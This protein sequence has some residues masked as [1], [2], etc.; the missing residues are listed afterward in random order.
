MKWIVSVV[1]VVAVM[2]LVGCGTV[3]GTLQGASQ[4][5]DKAGTWIKQKGK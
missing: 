2:T 1:S 3:G 5:L 4:D